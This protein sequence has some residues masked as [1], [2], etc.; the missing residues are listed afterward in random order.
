MN[1][2]MNKQREGKRDKILLAHKARKNIT[3]E[4]VEKYTL[5]ILGLQE[6]RRANNR[7]D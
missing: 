1:G 6:L 2:Q 5:W 4:K 3:Y 7:W